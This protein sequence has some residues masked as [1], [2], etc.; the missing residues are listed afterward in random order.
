LSYDLTLFQP[1]EG[2]DPKLTYQN[3]IE[4]DERQSG[5]LE[6]Y[7]KRA[8]PELVRTQ[9]QR[10]ADTLKSR[11][12]AFTQ[13]QPD[14]PQP[15]IELNDEDLQVQVNVSEF[16][17]DIT[18]PYFRKGAG[19]MIECVCDCIHVLNQDAGYLAYDSQL[20]WFVTAIDSEDMIVKY[21]S[22]DRALPGIITQAFP[23]SGNPKRPW[24]K[25]W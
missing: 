21:R 12:P 17:V 4:Q 8:I 3:L 7:L 14:A 16:K 11:H 6:Q 10:V 22:M 19:G 2:V 9:M 25:I 1:V 5:D 20:D 18:M 13:F 24:W 15:W 23:P